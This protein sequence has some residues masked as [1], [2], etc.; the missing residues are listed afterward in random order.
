MWPGVV[1]GTRVLGPL[2]LFVVRP[3]SFSD[4]L[5]RV[6][7]GRQ[8]ALSWS[9]IVCILIA[10]EVAVIF[11]T[12]A[13]S[14]SHYYELVLR[15]KPASP[16]AGSLGIVIAS[17]YVV[18]SALRG[19][20]RYTDL[21]MPRRPI[22]R[23]VNS[24][25]VTVV[26][27]VFILFLT[28]SSAGFSRG[29]F[30]I[31]MLVCLILLGLLRRVAA[32]AS[33]SLARAGRLD[34]RR[35]MLIGPPAGIAR[36]IETGCSCQQG[37]Q[38]VGVAKISPGDAALIS[39]ELRGAVEI[40]RRCRPEEIML[41]LEWKD[42]AVI[43]ECLRELLVLP[44]AITLS[45]ES[46]HDPVA[47]KSWPEP[48]R[49]LSI[50]L[51]RKPLTPIEI[52]AKRIFDMVG[53]SLC[54]VVLLPV[55]AG[56]ALAIGI[57][58]RGPILFR[59]KRYGFNRAPFEIFKFRSMYA[60]HASEPFR[61]AVRDDR[62]VTRVGR[63]IRKLNLDELPQL[64]NVLR[65]EMSLVGPRPHPV[66]LDDHYTSRVSLYARRHNVRPGIT[67]WAQVNGLR[68][69]TDEEWKMHDRLTHD[70]FYLDNWS[71]MF[72]IKILVLTVLT[73]KAFYNAA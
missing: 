1:A 57:E 71:V 9:F 39:Q 55:L 63:F 37:V 30:V 48:G 68:G 47:G 70:L 19:D 31:S 7:A 8:Q 38:V 67:G 13:L 20:Y 65:G 29:T 36:S 33:L 22:E 24:W 11:A 28:K 12:M 61:Q 26:C 51:A 34:A 69:V 15:A 66:D 25:F 72:D 46:F 3:M 21:A 49:L 73:P 40:G 41:A 50:S 10:F 58:S 53:A 14:E 2:L 16:S 32:A 6:S 43:Q 17:L 18:I 59:Q 56:I 45:L 27:V 62:R 42:G 23:L 5:V 44:A 52:V 64:I 54:L 35:I 60:A 4:L